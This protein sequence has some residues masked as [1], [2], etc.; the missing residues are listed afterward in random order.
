[1]E[2][3]EVVPAE[4]PPAAEET[5]QEPIVTLEETVPEEPSVES[6]DA[7]PIEAPKVIEVGDA[8]Q[9][10]EDTPQEAHPRKAPQEAQQ[11]AVVEPIAEQTKC[12]EET[13]AAEETVVASAENE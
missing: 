9:T 2:N 6:V 8:P 3:V 10:I 7:V 12:A 13:P 4:T 1:V 11:E 5:P